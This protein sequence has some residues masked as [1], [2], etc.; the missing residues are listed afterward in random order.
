MGR[1][2][3]AERARSIAGDQKHIS[4]TDSTVYNVRTHR[5]N[6]QNACSS[7]LS[8]RRFWIAVLKNKSSHKCPCNQPL[9]S[10]KRRVA[11][12]KSCTFRNHA[13]R[14]LFPAIY[15]KT[16]LIQPEGSSLSS[17]K[18]L[19]NFMPCPDSRSVGLVR[20]GHIACQAPSLYYCA[21]FSYVS[22]GRR[23]LAAQEATFWGTS[24]RF[25]KHNIDR[26]MVERNK[27]HL[28]STI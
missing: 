18:N 14:I 20:A 6:L 13:F 3:G 7:F 19:V 23:K 9:G 22:P 12:L 5:P 24:T 25:S 27:K 1:A 21:S 2:S 11:E 10:P 17:K 15:Q 28:F 8:L 26:I 16:L 4:C